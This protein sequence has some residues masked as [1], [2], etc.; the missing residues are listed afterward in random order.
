MNNLQNL[1][2]IPNGGFPPIIIID[3]DNDNDN[4]NKKIIKERGII[5]IQKLLKPSESL[6]LIN[7]N[8]N[9]LDEINE[10]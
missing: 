10:L 6:L 7:N 1:Q 2:N 4:D 9:I 5:N 8:D 3:N